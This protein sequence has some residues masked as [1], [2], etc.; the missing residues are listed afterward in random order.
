MED[1]STSR[2][3]AISST[4]VKR[5]T[6]QKKTTLHFLSSHNLASAGVFMLLEGII[7]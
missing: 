7:K 6:K 5:K 3:G 2:S 1:L 4:K